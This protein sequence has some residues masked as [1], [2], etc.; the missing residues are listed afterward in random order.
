MMTAPLEISPRDYH[1]RLS[2]DRS[3]IFSPSSWLSKSRLWELREKSLYRWRYHPSEFSGSDAADWGTLVDCLVTTPDEI[4]EITALHDYPD[5]R[6]KEARQ[7]RDEAKESGKILV[8]HERLNLA[9]RA[10]EKLEKH[11]V[12]GDIIRA[13]GKQV[14][15]LNRIQ[16]IQCKGLVD[17]APVNRPYLADLK[18]TG[19]FT[20]RSL[21]RTIEDLGYHVQA[22]FYLKLWNLCH[23]DDQRNRFRFIWQDSSPP[24]ETVVT[25]LPAHDIHA[26]EEWAA[27][28]IDRLIGATQKDYWPDLGGGKCLLIGR[29]S[30]AVY[31]DEEDLDG[32]MAVPAALEKAGATA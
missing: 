28:Q 16:G 8:D 6:T 29:T 26:G 21:E 24:F 30:S 20:L 19:R 14:V 2:L 5:F 9:R 18:T 32:P 17:L 11:P 25:E 31:R 23:P 4:E 13:S 12:A 1:T 10:A 15:L 7:F 22:A 3:D 27:H